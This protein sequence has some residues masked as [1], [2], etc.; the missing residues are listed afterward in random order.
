MSDDDSTDTTE[1]S[2]YQTPE[3]RE[4]LL[5]HFLNIRLELLLGL[6]QAGD[7]VGEGGRQDDVDLG[8]NLCAGRGGGRHHW[9]KR[10][11]RARGRDS[12]SSGYEEGGKTKIVKKV[13]RGYVRGF[14]YGKADG[15]D[16]T[17]ALR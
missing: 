14:R 3:P 2:S 11:K 12:I 5:L 7:L 10:D 6:G 13:F 4:G 8:V 9:R 17:E 1:T 15:K 16:G